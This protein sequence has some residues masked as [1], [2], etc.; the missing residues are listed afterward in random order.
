MYFLYHL[1]LGV[2]FK[3][4]MYMC[5]LSCVV[6]N[7]FDNLHIIMICS[8]QLVMYILWSCDVWSV[9]CYV[10]CIYSIITRFSISIIWLLNIHHK[11]LNIHK[12]DIIH[13]SQDYRIK[14]TRYQNIGYASQYIAR[15]SHR[16]NIQIFSNKATFYKPYSRAAILNCQYLVC[17]SILP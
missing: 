7:P 8:N 3:F 15:T 14:I 6:P 1:I 13:V 4:V 2:I 16:V 5:I 11:I 17:I 10:W 12:E 9:S